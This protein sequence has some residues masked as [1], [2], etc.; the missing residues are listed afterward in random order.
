MEVPPQILAHVA[1][2]VAAGLAVAYSVHTMLVTRD[3][4]TL[5]SVN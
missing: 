5:S 2:I 4:S 3:L 1:A